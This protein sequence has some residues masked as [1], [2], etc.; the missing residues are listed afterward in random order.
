[1]VSVSEDQAHLTSASNATEQVTGLPNAPSA[2]AEAPVVTD[3]ET[4]TEERVA[5]SNAGVVATSP[6]NAMEEEEAAVEVAALRD[7]TAEEAVATEEILEGDARLPVETTA[8]EVAPALAKV[9]QEDAEATLQVAIDPEETEIVV[10]EAEAHPHLV[11]EINVVEEV[12][13]DLKEAVLVK[14]EEAAR[15]ELLIRNKEE[16]TG[17]APGQAPKQEGAKVWT[18]E[19]RETKEAPPLELTTARRTTK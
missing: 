19:Q 13:Q 4:R 9:A 7:Q 18:V 14:V 17:L 1:M 2:E 16:V 11:L 5:A 15:A 6:G 10:I 3:R 8:G 12:P